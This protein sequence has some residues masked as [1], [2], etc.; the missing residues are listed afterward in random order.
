[1]AVPGS[2]SL[3]LHA[4]ATR[5]EL[6]LYGSDLERLRAAGE[7]AL[8]EIERL[9]AQLSFY[10]ADSEITRINANAAERPVRVE[11]RLFHLIWD[12][13]ALAGLTDGAFDITVGPLMRAWG[14]VGGAGSTPSDQKLGHAMSLIGVDNLELNRDD[15]EIS[16]KKK[17]VELDLGAYGKGYAIER[18][19]CVLH[20]NEVTSALLHGGTSSVCTIG[21]PPGAK[22]WRVA[23]GG[24]LKEKDRPIVIDLSNSSLSVSGVHGKQFVEEGRAYGHVIDPRSGGPV[25]GTLGA[26]VVGP[27]PA[28]C[29]ALSTALLVLGPKWLTV[30]TR[31]FPDY[32][33]YVAWQE[34]NSAI[35]LRRS[36]QKIP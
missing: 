7:E 28:E 2:I 16:F 14:F 12:C 32:H 10:K 27:S 13:V 34:P 26:A 23:L 17:G 5:F 20:D 3:S 30:M 35:T 33:G 11:P 21:S 8:L 36:S 18:A 1:M 19:V 22:A 4:M 25:C 15:Y 31:R 9:D 6:V 24:P 29:E